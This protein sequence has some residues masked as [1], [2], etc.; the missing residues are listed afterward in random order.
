MTLTA[1]TGELV[2]LFEF[3]D[4]LVK[5]T[6][7]VLVVEGIFQCNRVI[8]EGKLGFVGYVDEKVC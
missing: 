6:R 8:N 4:M 7:S 5:I 1:C 3:K 2:E